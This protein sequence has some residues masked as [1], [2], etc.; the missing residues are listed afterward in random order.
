[1]APETLPP[2]VERI[3]SHAWTKWYRARLDQGLLVIL[4]VE[5][6]HG[7]LWAHLSVTGRDRTPTLPELAWCKDLFLGDR[8]AIQ[9]FP[10]KAEADVA[11]TRTLHLHAPLESDALPSSHVSQPV[12]WEG[13]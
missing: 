4:E 5:C 13:R 1:M 6:W 3:A 8:K 9:I 2:S 11:G 10:R 7:E 12:A